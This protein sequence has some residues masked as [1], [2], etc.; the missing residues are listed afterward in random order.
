MSYGRDPMAGHDAWLEA[1]YQRGQEVPSEVEDYLGVEIYVEEEAAVGTV[2]DYETWQDADEDGRYGG[3]DL[4]VRF[5][6]GTTR[7]MRPDEVN[8]LLL[9]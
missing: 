2:D 4:I 9:K 5:P 8:D 1:P 6:D 7:N 3:V